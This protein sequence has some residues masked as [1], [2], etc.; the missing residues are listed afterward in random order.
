MIAYLPAV[1][2]LLVLAAHALRFGE[3]GQVAAWLAVGGLLLVRRPWA[4]RAVQGLLAAGVF[5]WTQVAADLVQMRLAMRAPWGRLALI[6]GA[7]ALAC[8]LA[9]WALEARKV[10]ERSGDGPAWPGALAFFLCL[11]LVLIAR[12]KSPVAVLLADRFWPGWGWLEALALAAYAGWLCEGV[13]DPARSARWRLRVWGLFSLV[14]FGQLV[15]GLLGAD[16]LLMTGRLHLPVPA[17]IVAG[18]LFRGHGLFMLILFASTVALVG[19]AWCS[20]LCYVGAWDGWAAS[21]RRSAGPLPAWRWPLRLALLG[22][23]VAAPLTLRAAGVDTLAA[24]WIAAGFG[25]AGVGIMAAVS[26]RLGVM[27]HCSAWCPIGALGNLLG[28]LNPFRVRMTADCTQCG[29]CSRAC[30]YDA[31]TPRDIDAGRPG[32]S[33]TL[34]GDCVGACKHTAMEYRFPGLPPAASRA[35]FLA[36]VCALHAAFLGVARI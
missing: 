30:R 19:P 3:A 9:A 35:L 12:A 20:W 28:R 22:L 24:V 6:M 23:A 33:C 31:L 13:L 11:G 34:C 25:L 4:R 26:R 32:L 15:L 7:V 36:L 18:P 29:A 27:A 21:G 16:Q 17:L 10:R 14:F 1:I 8:G 5:F 2:S